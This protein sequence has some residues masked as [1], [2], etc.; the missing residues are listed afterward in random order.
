MKLHSLALRVAGCDHVFKTTVI[1]TEPG[2]LNQIKWIDVIGLWEPRWSA[3]THPDTAFLDLKIT[4][5]KKLGG[6]TAPGAGTFQPK[7]QGALGRK[8]SDWSLTVVRFREPRWSAWTHPDTAV[9]DPKI[10]NQKKLGG[11]TG[12]RS[13]DISAQNGGGT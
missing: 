13:R 1:P 5:Q 6:L 7:M 10:T 9:L 11:L 2:S 8:P 12:A 4:N 3:W